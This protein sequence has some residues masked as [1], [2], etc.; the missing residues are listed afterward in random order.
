MSWTACP[1]AFRGDRAGGGGWK[2]L[3]EPKK[4]GS[5]LR[6]SLRG[7]SGTP[8][9]ERVAA[10]PLALPFGGPA[11]TCVSPAPHPGARLTR[12]LCRNASGRAQTR[13]TEDIPVCPS[14]RPSSGLR[15]D[16]APAEQTAGGAPAPAGT[17]AAWTRAAWTRAAWIRAA[18]RRQKLLQTHGPTVP[19]RRPGTAGSR[20]GVNGVRAQRKDGSAPV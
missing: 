16:H 5:A 1:S 8:E 17:R 20:P 15:A 19:P 9:A 7:A 3:R 12:S 14:V 11:R 18:G 10:T 4:A 13:V 6:G 2:Q